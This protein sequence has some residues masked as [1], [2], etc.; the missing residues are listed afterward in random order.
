MSATTG[1][2][3]QSS[4]ASLPA[5]GAF[6]GNKAILLERANPGI[7]RSTPDSDALASSDDEA[8]HRQ[9]QPASNSYGPKPIRRMSWLNEMPLTKK[10]STTKSGPYSPNTSHPATPAA[11]Q[12]T[13]GVT[14]SPGLGT[15]G[16]N[17]TT[18][19][20]PW[21]NS[22]I[23]NNENR[24]DPPSRLQ[25]VLPS[26]TAIS[27]PNASFLNEEFHSPS[28]KRG[29]VS[30]I[31]IPFSIP[32]HPTPKTYRSQSY[33]VGQLDPES[34]MPNTTNKTPGTYGM[35]RGRG[36]IHQPILQ[37]M[38]S[39]TS[40]LNELGHDSG[41]LGRV[42][43]VEDDEEQ[44]DVS[45]TSRNLSLFQARTIEQ[46]TRENAILRQAATSQTENRYRERNVSSTS[47]NSG[48]S[49]SANNFRNARIHSVVP[50]EADLA[51]ED[52]DEIGA[53]S[54]NIGRESLGRRY[55]E[56][57][58]VNSDRQQVSPTDNRNLDNVKRAQW[59]TS[60]G[61]GG[62]PEAP[63]SRRHS[64][65]DVPTRHG[66]ISST[67]EHSPSMTRRYPSTNSQDRDDAYGAYGEAQ[68]PNPI[69]TR[70][71]RISLYR[72]AEQKLELEH[73]H[74][75]HFAALYF[76]SPNSTRRNADLGHTSLHHAY[77]TP[78]TYGRNITIG[79][80]LSPH[81][82]PLYIVTFK[83]CRSDVFYIQEGTGL[84]VKPGDLVIVEADRG[85]DLGTV[86]HAHISWDEA[87]E[88]KEKYA[89]EHYNWLMMFSDQRRNGVP[90]AVNPNGLPGL[91]G[92]PGSAVGG[93]GPPSQQGG[94]EPQP[95]ELK[96]KL[97]KRLAQNHE[98][99][100]LRDKE[101][102]EAKAKRVCQQK[103]AEHRLSMEI[104]DAE[105]QM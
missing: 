85:T 73:L 100:T 92:A 14:A 79:T 42:H 33:S 4:K 61:F 48:L 11:E 15:G 94:Q 34:L 72:L 75:R 77:V 26:P 82:Q 35:I 25:E 57:S 19:S 84:Q 22:G 36:G 49:S 38:S 12:T 16:W 37:H 32:L 65:A 86:Q 40:G 60:L 23:W 52:L 24:K 74:N 78:N 27:S 6:P 7:R 41:P 45:D 30:E 81:A 83:C 62:I 59:Q 13:W 54:N 80:D 58:A 89:A 70:E 3:A 105:F 20:Y 101:G 2:S 56:L 87:R 68:D 69:D 71:F 18:S 102:N 64:F 104:L 29:N 21:G 1:R 28:A 91:N 9:S 44:E 63:Q 76:S 95:G 99:Q 96:P 51:V 10:P 17:T 47:A 46:L 103:V 90:N 98:I 88:L 55:S 53:P 5:F 67:G 66:S 93:M 8:D 43:E 97:I 31:A 39:R 50:E